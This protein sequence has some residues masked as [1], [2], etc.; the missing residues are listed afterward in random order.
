MVARAD[1]FD[2]VPRGFFGPLAGPLAPMYWTALQRFYEYEF[3]REPFFILRPAAVELIAQALSESPLWLERR[4]EL[5]GGDA[6]DA[7]DESDVRRQAARRMLDRLCEA[8]WIHFEYR[9]HAGGEVLNF[10][11]AAARILEVLVRTARDEQPVLQGYA[12]TIATLLKPEAFASNPGL[13]LAEAKRNTLDLIRELKILN[14]NIQAFTQRIL[15]DASSAAKILEEGLDRYHCAVMASYHRLKTVDNLYKWRTRILDRLHEISCDH[16][17]LDTAVT[18]ITEQYRCTRDEGQR[19]LEGDLAIMR[20]QFESLPQI[21][22]D[23]DRRNS[24]FSGVALR[25]LMYLL[26]QDRR[27]EAQLQFLVDQLA[28]TDVSIELDVYRCE[29]LSEGFLFSPRKR[30]APLERQRLADA[31]PI[32]LDRVRQD[33]AERVR[34]RYGRKAIEERVAMLLAGRRSMSTDAL[35]LDS[36]DDYV[37]AMYI[38]AY[39]LDRR[40]RFVF[41]VD[42]AAGADRTR[43]GPYK[44]P[45]GRIRTK[46]NR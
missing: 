9:A 17:S 35:P 27:T 28:T 32:D 12:H 4:E 45:R 25:K 2:R 13:A 38:D 1:L 6:A 3:E 46:R 40:A 5:L 16:A 23:L 22:D 21:T 14:R 7:L 29:L 43:T 15:D 44:I 24:R 11:A 8:G 19:R 26:R 18:W 42:D 20:S 10:H 33:A 37:A 31:A 36:D 39:G 30:R 34:R 41:E